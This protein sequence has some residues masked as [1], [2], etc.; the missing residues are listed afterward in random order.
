[1][2]AQ[3]GAA[4]RFDWGPSGAAELSRVCAALVVVDVLSFCT[5]VDVAVERGIR[6]HPFPWSEQAA[7]YADRIGAVAP[8]GRALSPVALRDAPFAADLVLS[9]PNGAAICATVAS[10]GVPVVAACLRNATAVARWLHTEG[11]GR[12]DAPIGV[13]AAGEQWPDGSLRPA[14][15]DL[16][17]AATVLDGLSVVDVALSV[18]AAVALAALTALPDAAAA[19]RGCASARE[20]IERGYAD[21][22]E[23]AIEVDTSAVVPV[24]RG[25]AFMAAG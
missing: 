16:L 4:A 22:V 21:D 20:L 1:M 3:R 24:L 14:V 19:I 5:A 13:V 11:Y 23:M 7:E 8:T 15:E 9:S 2:F 18:E 10:T 6:V 25:G 12:R 17:G